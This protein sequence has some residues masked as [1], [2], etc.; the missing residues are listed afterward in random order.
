MS[1]VNCKV[2][3]IRPE[4]DNLREWMEDKNNVYIGRKGIVFIDGKR[5][6]EK[7]SIFCNPYKISKDVSRE[8]VIEKYKSYIME[9][10]ENDKT[11]LKKLKRLKGKNLGC[12]CAPKKCHGDILLDLINS[13]DD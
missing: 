13:Y 9:K 1:V 7:S 11:F 5:Y 6:P 4:Y 8:E 2:C 10:I 12:W 3:N